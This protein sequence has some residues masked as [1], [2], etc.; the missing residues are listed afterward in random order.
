MSQTGLAGK[1]IRQGN[2]FIC[3]ID[4]FFID[5][6]EL[7]EQTKNA[8]HRAIRKGQ[9]QGNLIYI[10]ATEDLSDSD[11]ENA[12]KGQ[13]NKSFH[14]TTSGIIIDK[15]YETLTFYGI[16]NNGMLKKGIPFGSSTLASLPVRTVSNINPNSSPVNS[17]KQTASMVDAQN[18]S[19]WRTTA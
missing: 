19:Y 13:L 11:I 12:I 9:K 16:N 17:L 3:L 4:G 8:V 2:Y 10:T 7:E 6:K 18:N 5:F 14:I 15:G 1:T